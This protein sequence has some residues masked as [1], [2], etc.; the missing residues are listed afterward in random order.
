MLA[1]VDGRAQLVLEVKAEGIE[2]EVLAAVRRAKA[3]DWCVVHSFYPKI[4][5][6][7]R[8]LEPR[9]A[10]SYLLGREVRDWDRFLG[11]ALSLGAQGVSVHEAL[12]TLERV[13]ATR[14]RE[15]RYTAWTVNKQA[16]VRRVAAA[17]VDAIT[18]DYPDR[19]RRWLPKRA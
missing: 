13:R 5:E 11:F 19:V 12:T 9:L 4:V 10:A 2:E 15:M 3:I 8:T 6:R 16:D 1:A 7:F 14:L 18:T 17:G